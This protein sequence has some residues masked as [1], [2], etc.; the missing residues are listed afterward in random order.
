MLGDERA[1]EPLIQ[2]L[3]RDVPGR[4]LTHAEYI[5]KSVVVMALGYVINKNGSPSALNY[6]KENVKPDAWS[7]RIKWT[8]P[9]HP[10]VDAR[11]LQLSK[12]TI[13]GLGLSGNSSAAETLVALQGPVKTDDD[14]RFQMQVRSPRHSRP[15]KRSPRKDWLDTIKPRCKPFDFSISGCLDRYVAEERANGGQKHALGTY[16]PSGSA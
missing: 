16:T 15:T 5:A 9:Y 3:E 6:L 2:F 13:L 10:T 14:K 11:N 12:M 8:S 1:V 4:P 7:A